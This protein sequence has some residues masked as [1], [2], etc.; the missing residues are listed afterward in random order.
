MEEF[1]LLL[2]T[3]FYASL[4]FILC[5]SLYGIVCKPNLLKKIIALTIFADTANTFFILIGYRSGT[6]MPPVLRTLSPTSQDITKFTSLAVDPVPQCLVITAIVIN[7]AVT[8]LLAFLT[9]QIYRH[10]HS[11]DVREIVRLKG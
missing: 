2:W 11:L 4:A 9:I 1:R 3:F 7:M 5:V 8:M 10:R 6:V